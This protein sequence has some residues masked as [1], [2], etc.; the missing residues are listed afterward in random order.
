MTNK[1]TILLSILVV[2]V[3]SNLNAQTMKISG[4]VNDTINFKPL[5]DAS[6]VIIRLSDSVIVDY[7]WTDMYGRFSFDKLAIDTVEVLITHPKFMD[8]SYYVLGSATNTEVI[9]ENVI[10]SE[11]MKTMNEVV[12]F[13]TQN[14]VYYRGDT[15]V[16]VADSFDVKTNAVV[17]DLL[18]KLPGV[19][20]DAA[21]TIKFQ[22]KEVT[23]VLVD[24]DEFFGSDHLIATRNLD[25]RAVDNVEVYETEIENAS[26]GS[27]ETV[28]VMNLKLKEEAKQGYFGRVAAGSD[29][30][31][32]YEAEA[33]GSMFNGKRKISAYFQT[34]NTP[35][36]GLSW[37]D[38]RQYG[39]DNER[40]NIIDEDGDWVW[41]GSPS[42]EGLPQSNRGGL[43]FQD[44]LTEK[45]FVSLNYG[46]TDA[47]LE[48]NSDLSRQYFFPD[49][50]YSVIDEN[51]GFNRNVNHVV[52][53]N[54][55]YA[56]DSLTT[57]AIKPQIKML[58]V[59]QRANNSSRFLD[60]SLNLFSESLMDNEN[61]SQ[62]MSFSNVTKITRKF[63]KPTRKLE[64][65]HQ[66][67]F[68]NNQSTGLIKSGNLRLVDSTQFSVFDQR[69]EGSLSGVGHLA[70]LVYWEPINK[71]WRL[72]F[73]YQLNY[74]Q[75]S[76]GVRSYNKVGDFYTD[77]DTLY[78]NNFENK[79]IVNMFGAFGRYDKGKH[80]VRF[81]ARLRKNQTF[82]YNL[83]TQDRF[84]R[85]INNF[86][87]RITYNFKP[88]PSTRL[89]AT[90][91][92]DAQLPQISQLQPLLD[93]T[94]PNSVQIGN[95]NLVPAYINKF[96]LNFHSWN[97]L[98]SSY[99]WTGIY[100]NQTNNAFSNAIT[101][102]SDG[103]TVSEVVNVN[104]NYSG[105]FYGGYGFPLKGQTL[106][107]RLNL[108]GN[109]R[110][111]NNFINGLQNTTKNLS[112]GA[113]T[114][115]MFNNDTLTIDFSVGTNYNR[116]QS[117]LG[118]GSNQPF[119]QHSFDLDFEIEFFW[120]TRISTDAS[121]TIL[122]QR[123][124]GFNLN[125]FIWNMSISKRFLTGE[126][127]VL[128]L[129]ANDILNQNT[130]ISRN[131]T[132]NMIIDSRTQI[133][134]RYFLVKLTY[135]FKNKI[136]EKEKDETFD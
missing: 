110:N 127:L 75:T 98:K 129:Q 117:T 12:I 86:L 79:Q 1:F 132:T 100:A 113:S 71:F 13:A 124:D 49:S 65:T 120:N 11:N 135:Y 6:V 119:W 109:Y 72:E 136:K 112:A 126:N 36:S 90:Y 80:M 118:L 93:N 22:G 56:L 64:I 19:E 125:Y 106:T 61:E 51:R 66:V 97:G 43:F 107:M 41:F 63:K 7:A 15:L 99:I 68:Q 62:E 46:F 130:T 73:E 85:D 42:R 69:K 131:I 40:Q 133:I 92:T 45:L 2:L 17:E 103:Q 134:N 77:L 114:S 94:N 26:D 111:T 102:N 47:Q 57:I 50:T 95:A 28:Q 34:S 27:T 115:L 58:N 14:P 21:G 31:R 76:N 91:S 54:L 104:G 32:F 9:I 121:Y 74:F 116:P 20:V 101:F 84:D 52:N 78:S 67:D 37:E 105:G 83:Y 39:F 89:R 96:D 24:G 53:L 81:G 60:N 8:V 108:D 29:F 44:Q 82:N 25:A 123:A 35:N 70:R 87:P 128:E 4:E 18:K 23:K 88:K 55:E 59:Q 38:S 3:F 33:L 10:M 30:N 5:R 48:S 16:F 122:T